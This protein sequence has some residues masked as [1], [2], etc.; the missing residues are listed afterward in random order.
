MYICK[1]IYLKILPN[2]NPYIVGQNVYSTWSLSRFLVDFVIPLSETLEGKYVLLWSSDGRIKQGYTSHRFWNAC[3][4]QNY[5]I[6][7][8]SF[9]SWYGIFLTIFYFSPAFY[10]YLL[11]FFPAPLPPLPSCRLT[12]N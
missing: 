5:V 11:G 4:K 3:Q 9:L 1:I 7:A 6:L 2:L 12:I 8:F 10:P